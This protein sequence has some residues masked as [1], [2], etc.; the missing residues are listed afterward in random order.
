MREL[1]ILLA[2]ILFASCASVPRRTARG[3]QLPDSERFRK[4]ILKVVETYPTDGTHKYWW[5]KSG[6]WAGITRDVKYKGQVVAKGDPEGRCYCCGLTWEVFMRAL[7]QYN[8]GTTKKVFH[9]WT[10]EKVDHFRHMWFGSDGNRECL[11][12]AVL[13]YG[14]GFEITNK[15]KAKRGDFVQLWRYTGSGHSVIFDAW[16]RNDKG[17][18]TGLKYWSTQKATDG[19]GYRTEPVGGEKGI[20]LDETYIVRIGSPRR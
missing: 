9:D 10:R 16:E 1:V 7:E 12:N 13:S 4:E 8:N 5:P 11:R 20:R 2:C 3:P 6:T 14:V 19:I 15:D 17:E 18:I